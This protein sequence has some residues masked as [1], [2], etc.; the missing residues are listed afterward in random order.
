VATVKHEDI[1]TRDYES[2]EELIKELRTYFEFYNNE[3]PHQTFGGRKP[4]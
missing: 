4:A 3:R 1:H 2:V